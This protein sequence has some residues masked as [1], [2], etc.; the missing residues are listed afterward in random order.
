[1][2]IEIFYAFLVP[3]LPRWNIFAV[4]FVWGLFYGL[5][6]VCVTPE[7]RWNEQGFFKVVTDPYAYASIGG[8]QT[9]F[10]LKKEYSIN[11]PKKIKNPP[12][13]KY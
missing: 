12:T 11:I 8:G 5:E 9:P 3:P 4:T 7:D 1:M 13:K 2:Y 10:C 6:F